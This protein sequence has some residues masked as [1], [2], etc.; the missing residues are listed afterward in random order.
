MAKILNSNIKMGYDA[1][2]GALI[3]RGNTADVFEA[4]QNKAVKLFVPGYPLESVRVEFENSKL[5]NDL[6]IPIVKSHELVTHDGRHGILYDRVD[7]ESMLDILLRTQDLE[8]YATDLARLHKKLLAHRLPSAAALKA[9]LKRNVEGTEGLSTPRKS[10]L[11]AMLDKLPDGDR[12]CH[13]DF[14][15]GNV[16]LSQGGYVIIDY[17]NVCRGHEYGDIARTFYLIEMTPVPPGTPDAALFLQLKKEAADLY[18]KEMGVNRESLSQ[19]LILTAAARLW[20]LSEAEI[21]E[22]ES[23][24]KFLL[25]NDL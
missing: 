6:N 5:L 17:M 9:I 18:L 3:G 4:G 15:F 8:R 22:R 16:I 7:G 11:L 10:K 2:I 25:L 1:M 20:E 24:L 21:E 13:G 14:H 12:F 19:W 23:I